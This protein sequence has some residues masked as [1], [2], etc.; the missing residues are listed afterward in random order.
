MICPHCN[1]SGTIPKGYSYLAH[2]CPDCE[3]LGELSA[4]EDCSVQLPG[5]QTLCHECEEVRDQEEATE[6]FIYWLT[7]P[8]T[9]V[10]DLADGLG[11]PYI[12]R[13]SPL[14]GYDTF[15]LLYI[16]AVERYFNRLKSKNINK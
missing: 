5:D 4:C 15:R 11:K 8:T 10:Y 6:D 14:I 12:Y 1:G 2:R 7:A 3:G 16:Q 13:Q 9:T